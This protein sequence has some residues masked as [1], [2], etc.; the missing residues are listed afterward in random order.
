MCIHSLYVFSKINKIKTCS[1]HTAD[2]EFFFRK[3]NGIINY[4]P[5]FSAND[6]KVDLEQ[7]D[8][9]VVVIET[10]NLSDIL[11]LQQDNNLKYFQVNQSLRN[12]M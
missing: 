5:Y 6:L 2:V 11:T 8:T 10:L 9:N 4:L 1:L 12:Q 7:T 3:P